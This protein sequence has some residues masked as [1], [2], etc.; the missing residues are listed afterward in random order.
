[1]NK[2]LV[3]KLLSYSVYNGLTKSLL[4]IE[5]AEKASEKEDAYDVLRERLAKLFSLKNVGHFPNQV[6]V[7]FAETIQGLYDEKDDLPGYLFHIRQYL[8]RQIKTYTDTSQQLS[9][10][11]QLMRKH[12]NLDTIERLDIEYQA[13]TYS[14]GYYKQ[15]NEMYQYL[16][17]I[18]EQ[19]L[20]YDKARK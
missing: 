11:V 9:R 1:M 4:S 6:M 2:E 7:D 20:L 8:Y 16:L 5:K 18:I 15:Q 14:H 13:W 19:V 17:H 3:R 10:R 12:T